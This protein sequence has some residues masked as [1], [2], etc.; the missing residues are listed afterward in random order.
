MRLFPPSHKDRGLDFI[1][2][3]EKS[4]N[5]LFLELI[6][7]LVNFGTKLDFFNVNGLLA[8]LGFPCTLLLLVLIAPEI[9]DAA[10]RR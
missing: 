8:F 7:M 6:V 5:V 4:L 3:G 9:H 2:V 1:A 10:H